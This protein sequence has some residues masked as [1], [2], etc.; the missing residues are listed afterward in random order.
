MVFGLAESEAVGAGGAGGGGGGGGAVFFAHAPR[1]II[2]PSATT[3]KLHFLIWCFTYLLQNFCAPLLWRA[4]AESRPGAR[5]AGRKTPVHP[6]MV[7]FQLQ[8]GCELL[9]FTVNCL[10]FDPSASIVHI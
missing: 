7:Y 10:T 8:L 9:P 3:S 5:L 2:V 4:F 6:K 1:N